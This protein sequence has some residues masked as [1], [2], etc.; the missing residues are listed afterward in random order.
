LVL[1][2]TVNPI[3]ASKGSVWSEKSNP[4]NSRPASRHREP[5][6][7]LEGVGLVGE[8]EPAE[9]QTRL[10]AQHVEGVEAERP[11]TE[12]FAG[13][14]HGVPQHEA[15]VRRAPQLVTQLAGIAGA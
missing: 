10:D 6:T 4:P 3:P 11:K 7:R 1:S 14:P 5:D 13:L 8:V 15:V 2:G 9:H 12:R